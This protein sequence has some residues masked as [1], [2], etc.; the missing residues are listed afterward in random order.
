[1]N[2][3]ITINDLHESQATEWLDVPC[4]IEDT[5]AMMSNDDD[6]MEDL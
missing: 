3:F 2:E 1:M 5:Y 6:T 4:F